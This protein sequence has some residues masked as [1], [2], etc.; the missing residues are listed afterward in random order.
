MW[1]LIFLV[2]TMVLGF[3]LAALAR[4][5]FAP[6]PPRLPEPFAEP[7][8]LSDPVSTTPDDTPVRRTLFAVGAR[9]RALQ[10]YS[11]ATSVR[12]QF[13]SGDILTFKSVSYSR[14]DGMHAYIFQASDGTDKDWLL[15]DTQ[16]IDTWKTF[17]ELVAN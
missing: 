16:P 15:H 9:Y 7:C 12:S 1:T 14:Y 3:G 2:A 13:G 17:F 4:N 8:A 11:V 10:D 6:V 5:L